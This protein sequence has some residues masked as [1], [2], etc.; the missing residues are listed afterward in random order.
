MYNNF[1]LLNIIKKKVAHVLVCDGLRT[2]QMMRVV[3]SDYQNPAFVAAL[4]VT[5]RFLSN[6]VTHVHGEVFFIP[7]SS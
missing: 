3:P 5:N 6:N 2:I 7:N 1:I 4:G